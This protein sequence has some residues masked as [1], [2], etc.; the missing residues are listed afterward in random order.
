MEKPVS[1]AR[2]IHSIIKS[3]EA[4]EHYFVATQ[5]RTLAE[6]LKKRPGCPVIYIKLNAILLDRPSA[7]SQMFVKQS[8][9]EQLV[10]KEELERLKQLKETELPASE[11]TKKKRKVVKGPHPMSCRKKKAKPNESDQLSSNRKRKRTRQKVAK[12]IRDLLDKNEVTV[13]ICK[14]YIWKCEANVIRWRLVSID[15]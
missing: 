14:V 8:I 9:K 12:H 4:T 6:K 15:F 3:K 2:C 1:A 10:G 11:M 7:A 13:W 5:D